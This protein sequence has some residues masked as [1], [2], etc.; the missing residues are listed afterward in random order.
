MMLLQKSYTFRTIMFCSFLIKIIPHVLI[1]QLIL[2]V[3]HLGGDLV[4]RDGRKLKIFYGMSSSTAMK[5]HAGGI[6]EY[7]LELLDIL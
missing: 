4:E 6:A 7:R 1:P 3:F 5:K 2:I